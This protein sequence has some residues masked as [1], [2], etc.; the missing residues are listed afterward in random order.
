[1][2]AAVTGVPA[3]TR[4]VERNSAPPAWLVTA[5]CGIA[6]TDEPSDDG[7]ALKKRADEAQ[8]RAKATGRKSEP[9]RSVVTVEDG[10]QQIVNPS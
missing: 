10:E 4:L 2:V 8:Y 5:S 1:M 7:A 6:T 9:K 3:A